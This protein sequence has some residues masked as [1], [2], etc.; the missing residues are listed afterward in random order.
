MRKQTTATRTAAADLKQPDP[1][2]RLAALRI[3]PVSPETLELLDR[4]V[5][6]FL[7]WQA[8][9]NLV[10]PST[11]GHLWTRHIADSLQLLPLASDARTFLDLGS[12]G[13]FPGLVIACALAQ[14]PGACVHLVDS[15]KR[16]A[17][18]LRE[19]VRELKIPAIVHC[20]RIEDVAI[21]N[22][23]DFEVVTARALAPLDRLLGLMHPFLGKDARGML[24]KGQDVEVELTEAS[25]SWIIVADLVAS[26][27]SQD[28]RILI[29]RRLEPRR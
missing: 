13:G 23:Q 3:T 6:L 1:Q 11:V 8:K 28:G 17:A 29:I 19:A 18:F 5:E 24:H 10:A 26:E 9:A 15:N 20:A 25:K 2:D 14:T 21:D 27:T 16:K 12:G 22:L 4:F 7:A